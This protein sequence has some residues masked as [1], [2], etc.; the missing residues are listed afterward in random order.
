MIDPAQASK[1]LDA[2]K[3]SL[4]LVGNRKPNGFVERMNRLHTRLYY[5]NAL[6]REMS[7]YQVKWLGLCPA[8]LDEETGLLFQPLTTSGELA[9]EGVVM[10]H[11][12][13]GYDQACIEGSSY[14]FGIRL[15]QERIATMEIQDLDVNLPSWRELHTLEK[16][17]TINQI[18]EFSNRTAQSEVQRASQRF[19]TELKSGKIENTLSIPRVQEKRKGLISPTDM[20][21]ALFPEITRVLMPEWKDRSWKE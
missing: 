14:I 11:C 2:N 20:A 5:L 17:L 3:V 16:R 12:V 6:V 7:G 13:G 15:G 8:W 1:K 19:M 10:R 9:E 21:I 4:S 18:K